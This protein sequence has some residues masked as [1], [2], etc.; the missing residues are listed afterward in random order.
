MD[1]QQKNLVQLL[2]WAWLRHARPEK[3]ATLLAALDVAAPGQRAV[4]R[5]LALALVRSNEPQRALDVL[6]RMAVA[7]GRDA[8]WHLLRARA[9][10]ACDR[11]DEAGLAM[12]ACLRAREQEMAA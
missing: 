1:E 9:L 4:L 2:A 6:D 7:G 5:A 3:A 12:A 8:A 11:R 10:A